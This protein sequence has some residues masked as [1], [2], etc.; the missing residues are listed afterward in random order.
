MR[1]FTR[2][3]D[4]T[5]DRFFDFIYCEELDHKEVKERLETEGIDIESAKK[6]VNQLLASRKLLERS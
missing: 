4:K 1:D 2:F 5:W 6:R 3:D